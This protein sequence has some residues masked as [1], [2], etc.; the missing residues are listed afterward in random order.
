MARHKNKELVAVGGAPEGRA[1]LSAKAGLREV[2]DCP[3]NTA[4]PSRVS[5]ALNPGYSFY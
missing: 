5:L 2:P 4:T 1:K 3:F